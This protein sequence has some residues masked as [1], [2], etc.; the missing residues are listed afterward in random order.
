MSECK[1]LAVVAE[2]TLDSCFVK[3]WRLIVFYILNKIQGK[4]LAVYGKGF[5]AGNFTE[6]SWLYGGGTGNHYS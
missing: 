2:E 4:L 5:R 3:F 6:D 1:L